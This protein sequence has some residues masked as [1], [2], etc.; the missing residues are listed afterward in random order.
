MAPR[1]TKILDPAPPTTHRAPAHPHAPPPRRT[2]RRPCGARRGRR[3]QN[4]AQAGRQAVACSARGR[5][6]R[7]LGKPRAGAQPGPAPA[8][9][10][11][12]PGAAGGAAAGIDHP[13]RRRLLAADAADGAAGA[14]GRG[15][16]QPRAGPHLR[17]AVPAPADRADAALHHLPARAQHAAQRGQHREPDPLRRQRGGGTLADPGA[18]EDRRRV[19]GLLPRA[20]GRPRAARPGRPGAGHRAAGAAHLRAAAG[21]G[22]QRAE[23]HLLYQPAAHR[24]AAQARAG[25]APRPADHPPADPRAALH[26]ALPAD[27]CQGLP[28]PG[29]DRRED[30]ARVRPLLHQAGPGGRS[31]GRL[32]A[33]GDGARADGLPGGRAADVGRRG[34]PGRHRQLR[35]AAR[36]HLLRLRCRTAAEVG[37][38]R[39]GLPGQEAGGRRRRRAAG[40][41][42]HQDR[43]PQPGPRVP[44]GQD[45]H[46]ADAAVQPVLGAAR[47]ADA[48]P[49]GDDGADRRLHRGLPRRAAVRARGRHPGALRAAHPA[50]RRVARAAGVRGHRTHHRDG[51][52][53]RRGQHLARR[54]ALQAARC[55]GLPARPGAQVHALRC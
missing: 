18:A 16:V 15:R 26:P 52:R 49:E 55:A 25:G 38:D 32:P 33:R 13:R 50:R 46:R 51:I 14:P 48:L 28:R 40:A 10:R 41:G 1:S 22:D 21:G 47:Q 12:R 5:C 23:G 11:G 6:G 43:P 39:L 4:A 34:A 35:Q 8:A 9:R 2:A 42:G 29:A 45:L 20:D 31:H 44:D 30:G 53:G 7:G 37:L 17:R 19:L 3:P 27:R 24:R 36:G 54:R